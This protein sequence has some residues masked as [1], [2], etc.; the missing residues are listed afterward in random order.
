VPSLCGNFY[1]NTSLAYA[2]DSKAIASRDNGT[3]RAP[4][5]Y[6]DVV[7]GWIDPVQLY[8]ITSFRC[9]KKR[10]WHRRR[11]RASTPEHNEVA[12]GSKWSG[13]PTIAPD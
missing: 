12:E 7:M 3:A 4:M 9:K 13:G 6:V 8:N 1:K 2:R 5:P 10:H 11:R